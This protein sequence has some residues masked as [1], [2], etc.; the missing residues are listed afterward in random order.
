M[1]GVLFFIIGFLLI[2]TIYMI[3]K[4]DT[5][6]KVVKKDCNIKSKDELHKKFK[7]SYLWACE[8]FGV[9]ENVYDTLD[10]ELSEYKALGRDYFIFY[11]VSKYSHKYPITLPRCRNSIK[12][13]KSFE[14]QKSFANE[15]INIVESMRNK[16]DSQELELFKKYG[17]NYKNLL[18]ETFQVDNMKLYSLPS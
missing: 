3:L 7:E 14:Q 1:G 4:E 6:T 9:S 12:D 8:V 18:T 16:I 11:Y 2:F 5:K 10:K 17:I 15:F 13:W